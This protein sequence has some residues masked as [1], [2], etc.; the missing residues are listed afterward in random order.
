M[1]IICSNLKTYNY[2]Q[3]NERLIREFYLDLCV[4]YLY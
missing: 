2:V 1:I 3:R 4:N